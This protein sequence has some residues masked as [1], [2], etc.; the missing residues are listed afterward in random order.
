MNEL[1]VILTFAAISHGLARLWKMPVIPLLICSGL[2]LNITSLLPSA[3]G[4]LLLNNVELGLTFLVF[5]AGIELNPRRMKSH[6]RAIF[7]VGLTQ[8]LAM[9][10]GGYFLSKMLGYSSLT[11]L[12]LAFAIGTS[13]TLVV[14]RLL[15][16]RQ[17]MFEPFGRLVIGVLLLQDLI[18]IILIVV[19]SRLPEG[20]GAVSWGLAGATVCGAIAW[21]CQRYI[22]PR[23]LMKLKP[24]P[25]FLLLLC[26]A[27]LF[28]FLGLVN[29]LGLPPFIGAFLA[30]FSLSA[31]PVN[32]VVRG[33]LTSLTDFFQAVFFIILGALI[34]FPSTV[35]IFAGIIFLLLLFIVT[36]P[37]VTL[38]AELHGLSSRAAIESGLL[39]A[40]VSEFSLVL[41]L[42]GLHFGHIDQSTMSLIAT[43]SVISM[44]LTPLLTTEWMTRR[45]LHFHPVRRRQ[46]TRPVTKNHVLVLGFGSGGMWVI[47]PLK[48][49]GYDLLVV[50]D[51]PAV[52]EQLQKQKIP[53]LRGDASDEKLLQKAGA[54]HARLILAAMRRPADA[55]RV[56]EYA[57]EIP[58]I[59]RVFEEHD[60]KWIKSM[61]GIPVLNSEAALETFLV[62][63]DK[64]KFAKTAPAA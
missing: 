13:S 64:Q 26:L 49:E 60:A 16:V 36:P 7:L 20:V 27:F 45:F 50:D 51:D 42:T 53:C 55:R 41:G 10:I 62:W 1:A 61:G 11:S 5:A 2:I 21:G 29:S 38:V 15:R 40:Q 4:E 54:P 28:C 9:A 3:D 23:L 56:L 19:S 57:R 12:Y 34:T 59:I 44:S 17:Q 8:L 22:V 32:G 6:R 24:D 18:M 47:R 33:V 48:Q 25:E 37:V 39:L 31:F 46:S 14:V 30:G 52:I 63:L 35:E 58:T 43:I